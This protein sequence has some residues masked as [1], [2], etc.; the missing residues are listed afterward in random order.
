MRFPVSVAFVALAGAL[1][2]GASGAIGTLRAQGKSQWDGVYGQEQ[3]KRC[4]GIYST[5]CYSCH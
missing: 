5:Y 2:I 1:A 4:E 3:S